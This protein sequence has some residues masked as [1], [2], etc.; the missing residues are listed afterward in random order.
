MCCDVKKKTRFLRHAYEN[1]QYTL[2]EAIKL[3]Q[4]VMLVVLLKY[5]QGS[6][7]VSTGTAYSVVAAMMVLNLVGSICDAHRSV[8]VQ[9]AAMHLRTTCGALIYQKVCNVDMQ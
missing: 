7:S 5:L 3:A 8:L 1:I 9:V 2:Q 4:P 6:P